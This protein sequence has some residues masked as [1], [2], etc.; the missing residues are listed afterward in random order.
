MVYEL[1]GEPEKWLPGDTSDLRTAGGLSGSGRV[2]MADL[3]GLDAIEDFQDR[4][5]QW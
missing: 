2:D 3:P 4:R 5:D 1:A